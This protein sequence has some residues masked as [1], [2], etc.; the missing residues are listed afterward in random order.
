MNKLNFLSLILFGS[1]SLYSQKPSELMSEFEGRDAVRLEGRNETVLSVEDDK[2]LITKRYSAK[3]FLN[4]KGVNGRGGVSLK[5]EPPF[6]EITDI[7]AYTLVP[8]FDRDRYKKE[9]VRDIEDRKMIDDNVFH[10]GTRA[11]SFNFEGMM[12][13]AITVL[14]YEEEYHEPF[15]VGREVF[16]PY[17]YSKSQHFTLE[18]E[19]GIEIEYSYF[20]CDSSFFK[21]WTEEKRGD[22]IH[23]WEIAEMNTRKYES[24]SP[25]SLYISPH[26][27]YRIKSFQ[28]SDGQIE[29][30]LGSVKDL[31]QYYQK[32]ISELNS[33]DEELKT[34][35]DSIIK[36]I[37]EPRA[38]A[39]AIYDWVNHSIRYIAFEDGYGGFRP[40]NA[41]LVCTKRYGDCKDMSNLMVQ[42]MNYAGLEAYH[43]W[44]G[45]RDIPYTYEEVPTGLSDNHMIAALKLE[46]E[47]YFLDAT[48]KTLPFPYASSFTQGKQAL[49]NIGP[50]EYLLKTVPV[51]DYR[52]NDDTDSC[53]ITIEGGNNLKGSGTKHYG[54]YNRGQVLRV[55]ERKDD[56][57]FENWLTAD[58][59]K[60]D[61]RCK[62][63]LKD[64]EI[65]EDGFVLNYTMNLK[66][67]ARVVGAKTIINLN[68][69][70]ILTNYILEEDRKNPMELNNTN[71]FKRYYQLSIP[72][73]YT[74]DY[75]PENGSFEHP[76]FSF[77]IKYHQEGDK[78]IYEF[79]IALKSLFVEPES[80]EDWN[81]F[82]RS[83]RK[84]YQQTI[85]LKS[86]DSK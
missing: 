37:N 5:Y 76:D 70:Q 40:R 9:R 33:P 13:G 71:L 77:F 72:E 4:N 66:D 17:I 41:N 53:F 22:I 16:D 63:N 48:N 54:V 79:E 65:T 52:K 83:L 43:V 59:E 3:T 10:D 12:E 75:L 34:L 30:V 7:D 64:Y 50:E 6:S 55:L 23:H 47:I 61:N 20:N 24:G 69:E 27:V 84:N 18:V 44:I 57:A 46:D 45:T 51:L 31:H 19:K 15:L 38:K 67:Y 49:I 21:H 85:I 2:I 60:G 86:N 58:L 80:H 32:F 78:L 56:E 74:V 82:I 35:T 1:L 42:M 8:D 73:G 14:E 11:K 62:T 36:G 26:I 28:K 39:K 29:T 68:L 81:K 25:S